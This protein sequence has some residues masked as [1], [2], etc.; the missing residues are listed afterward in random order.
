MPGGDR[1]QQVETYIHIDTFHTGVYYPRNVREGNRSPE[2]EA[3]IPNSCNNR[4][5]PE[6]MIHLIIKKFEMRLN[7]ASN[8][9]KS[10]R[11]L[12]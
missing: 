7:N 6:P 1:V 9:E 5:D 3:D 2:T 4:R 8:G 12:R 10:L 11:I